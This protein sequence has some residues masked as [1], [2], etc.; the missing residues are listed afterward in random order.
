MIVVTG[1]TGNVG[2]SLVQALAV[3][4]E[5]V[6]AVSRGVSGDAVPEGVLHRRADLTDPESLRPVLDGADALFLHDGG[7]SGRPFG[8]RDVLDVVR[9]CGVGRIVLLSS[10]GVVTRPESASHGG[11]A[12]SREDAVRQSGADWTILRP[13]GFDSNAYAWAESVRARRAVAAP[14]GD[15][16]LPTVDPADIA[17]VA[18]AALRDGG[19][20][21]RA[22]ELTGPELVTPRQQAA[23]LGEA[24]GEP[25]RFIEQ[26]QD[27][28]RA[29]MLRFMPEPVAETTLDILGRPTPAEQ[30][31]SPDIERVLG[32]APRTFADWARRHI[33]A[34]R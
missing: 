33:A 3:A 5:K 1:A 10:Q 24:L 34:F 6:T 8:P 20:A 11:V 9:A 31:I 15:I 2:R 23:S 12:R 26:T 25:I 27:E 16:G 22:Y 14:F 13:G 29:Q 18:A 7:G 30:R 28:A 19:H 4:G 21:G 32:R 17:E